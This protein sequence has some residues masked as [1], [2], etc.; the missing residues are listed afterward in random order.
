[1]N[2][3]LVALIVGLLVLAVGVSY[4]AG[5]ATRDDAAA[6]EGTK[7]APTVEV[8][9]GTVDVP[10]LGASV[11][12]PALRVPKPEPDQGGTSTPDSGSGGTTDPGTSTPYT[13]T[14]D[15]QD[16]GTQTTPQKPGGND[17]GGGE[18]DFC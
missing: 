7:R 13:G 14:P 16:N 6:S 1:M 15:T 2:G 10:R 11:A 17:N 5:R 8:S 3:R 18:C 9:S 4:A 12:V